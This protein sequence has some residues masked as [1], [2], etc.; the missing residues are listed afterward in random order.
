LA[1]HRT[2]LIDGF[3]K[4]NQAP[5]VQI[6]DPIYVENIYDFVEVCH[7]GNEYISPSV[8]EIAQPP[9]TNLVIVACPKLDLG[10]NQS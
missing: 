1:C 10:R 2:F 5:N 6:V 9:A 7:F 8:E 3:Y 4:I